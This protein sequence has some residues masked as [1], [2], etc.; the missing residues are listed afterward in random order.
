MF[1][2]AHFAMLRSPPRLGSDL[3]DGP[4]PPVAR[5]GAAATL[6]ARAIEDEL[7]E[8]FFTD[9]R[10]LAQVIIV[11]G[12]PLSFG[13][14]PYALP[15]AARLAMAAQSIPDRMPFMLEVDG[16][17]SKTVN[18]FLR[19]LPT[20]GCPSHHSWRGYAY[21][22]KTFAHFLAQQPDRPTLLTARLE[23][24]NRFKRA[25]AVATPSDRPEDLSRKTMPSTWN[26]S[27]MALD[28]FYSWAAPRNPEVKVPFNYKDF[29]AKFGGGFFYGRRNTALSREGDKGL[30]KCISLS[31]Y[32][33]F[34]DHG[35]RGLPAGKHAPE[36]FPGRNAL[37]NVAFAETAITTGIR[38][39]EN[40]SILIG[41][42]PS[43]EDQRWEGAKS[44][45]MA[46]GRMTTK[47]N[48]ARKIWMPKRVLRDYVIPYMEEDRDNSV[49]KGFSRGI[50]A[51]LEDVVGIKRWG[52][53]EC[54][55]SGS[56]AKLPYDAL[57]HRYRQR[58]YSVDGNRAAF[59]PGMLWLSEQGLPM[60][61]AS[62]DAV[63][64]RAC[65]R[66]RDHCGIDL[67]VTPHTLRHTFAVYML[68]HLVR[69]VVERISNLRAE[70]RKS[71][72]NAYTELVQ[73]PL[74]RLQ[75]ILGHASI[76]TTQIYLT[77]IE[78]ADELV[79]EA[80][81]SWGDRLGR[82][83]EFFNAESDHDR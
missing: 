18:E 79:D 68:G 76:E 3:L 42:V 12:K 17:Y 74:R 29:T 37:R 73:D 71:K 59:E 75:R 9:S 19:S 81:G 65:E 62:F 78:E 61:A 49:A 82:P 44:C 53:R 32:V 50:Y 39:E 16:S 13:G 40:A 51:G 25:R 20:L 38:L 36:S 43:T 57:D 48:K 22:L 55:V 33:T 47:G 80:I 7:M 60:E 52:S 66:L 6:R 28:K 72:T 8:L 34:R 27:V 41:E 46:L 83:A 30:I 67:Q 10:R 11:D 15:A 4:P 2:P 26:R 35:L 69:E 24:V 64:T 70:K 5:P 54:I 31:E 14:K 23:H 45:P 56:G 63:F 1:A 77:Y 21:D 58:L